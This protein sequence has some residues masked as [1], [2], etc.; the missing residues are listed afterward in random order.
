MADFTQQ[1]NLQGWLNLSVCPR[2]RQTGGGRGREHEESWRSVSMWA[3]VLLAY[4][5][6]KEFWNSGAGR[7]GPMRSARTMLVK[8]KL[9]RD[10]QPLDSDTSTLDF[11]SPQRP[12]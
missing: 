4:H 12:S 5:V 11:L 3:N 6:S 8:A 2:C 7:F 1:S 9:G 10:R